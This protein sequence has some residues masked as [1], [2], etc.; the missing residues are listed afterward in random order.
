MN[1]NNQIYIFFTYSNSF[2]VF[3]LEIMLNENLETH[4]QFVVE[5][6]LD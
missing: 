3:S 5:R 6:I 2:T 4:N 1:D